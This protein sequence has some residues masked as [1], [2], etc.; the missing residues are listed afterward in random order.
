MPRPSAL[1]VGERLRK[2]RYWGGAE[3]AE[4]AEVVPR[5]AR[6]NDGS[7]GVCASWAE[8][9]LELVELRWVKSDGAG[10]LG[11]YSL[12]VLVEVRPFGFDLD[13]D[14][15]AAPPLRCKV[16]DQFGNS[17]PCDRR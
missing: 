2:P 17:A 12:R 9:G 11:D 15:Q 7:R 8:R 5:T 1:K 10:V 13:S 6:R 4:H 14:P 3:C 16:R